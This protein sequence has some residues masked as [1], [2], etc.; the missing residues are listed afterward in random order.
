[1]REG[2]ISLYSVLEKLRLEYCGQALGFQYKNDVELSEQI[3]KRAR[4]VEH[5]CYEEVEAIELV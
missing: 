2:I 5:P 4:K 1:M 3:Q